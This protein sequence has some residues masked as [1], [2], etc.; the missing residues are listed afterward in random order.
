MTHDY[1]MNRLKE[2]DHALEQTVAQHN[3]LHGA[4][5]ELLAFLKN[6]G[7]ALA[8][9]VIN[10]TVESATGVPGVGTVVS[11]IAQDV[12]QQAHPVSEEVHE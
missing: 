3:A 2:L 8:E 11:E 5:S 7:T 1:I 4:R 12:M 6:A 10:D 9:G